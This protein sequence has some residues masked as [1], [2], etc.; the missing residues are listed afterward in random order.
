MTKAGAKIL[1]G[2]RQAL[3]YVRC[4]HDWERSVTT[5]KANMIVGQV[6][7]CA[8]CGTRRTQTTQA[9]AVME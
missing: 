1:E 4:K 7:Y 8:K 6:D 3:E 5:I 2:A 9:P